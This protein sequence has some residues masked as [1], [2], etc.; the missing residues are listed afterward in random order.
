MLATPIL[1]T[2]TIKPY[3]ADPRYQKGIYLRVLDLD[4]QYAVQHVEKTILNQEV[5]LTEKEQE[6]VRNRIIRIVDGNTLITNPSCS[7]GAFN[8]AFHEGRQCPHC[9]T[10]S[11]YETESNLESKYW[12][13]APE[14]VKGLLHPACWMLLKNH[15]S[16]TWNKRGGSNDYLRYL[17]DPSYKPHNPNHPEM[18]RVMELNIPRGYNYFIEN[19]DNIYPQLIDILFAKGQDKKRCEITQFIE[20]NKKFF[21]PR[22]I[23]IPNNMCSVLEKDGNQRKMLNS[24]KMMI[25]A[26]NYLLVAPAPG[27]RGTV[28]AI[29]P[30][31]LEKQYGKNQ[32]AAAKFSQ[33]LFEFYDVL[34]KEDIG[35]KEGLIRK[36]VMGFR[37]PFSCRAVITLSSDPSATHGIE[38]PWGVAV[39][40][41]KDL[42]IALL[43]NR[44]GHTPAQAER[45]WKR[46]TER[47]HALVYKCLEEAREAVLD[48]LMTRFPSLYRYS[49]QACVISKIK[50]DVADKTFGV[51]ALCLKAMNGDFDGDEVSIIRLHDRDLARLFKQQRIEEGLLSFNSCLEI[52][53]NLSLCDPILQTLNTYMHVAA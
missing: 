22:Y 2:E 37:S 28:V 36:D 32:L 14:G 21:F 50:T 38:F 35:K 16:R 19:F 48:I 49:S 45:R 27:E 40:V 47:A 20:E 6:R 25:T 8:K 15:F 44:Y 23:P 4:R 53:A 13:E 5:I 26:V 9:L 41:C 12:L 30:K 11:R 42:I 7:C 52:S 33:K 29:E 31:R 39:V 51:G 1:N 17:I 24:T 3:L 34:F 18:I 10:I 43:Q 46:S